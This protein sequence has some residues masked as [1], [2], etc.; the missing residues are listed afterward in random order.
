MNKTWHSP[1]ILLCLALCMTLIPSAAFGEVRKDDL[2][3]GETVEL[4]GLPASSAPAINANYAVLIDSDG[5]VYFERDADEKT[6][7]ASTT[8]MMTA[9]VALETV[10][11][12]YQIDVS[13]RAASVGE[14]SAE[15]EAGDRLTL[16]E[17]L[18]GLMVPSGNDVAVAIA[19]CV[20]SKLVD[21]AKSQDA[22]I[23]DA[24]GNAIDLYAPDASYNAFVAKMNQRA[25]ELGCSNTRF[26][27]PHGL[28][29]GEWG[30]EE[31]YSTARDIATMAS[32]A[33]E[34][35]T[36]REV[37]S[38]ARESMTVERNGSSTAINLEPTDELIGTYEDA[39]G[40][41][42]GYTE[43][44]GYCF[45]GAFEK[46][47]RYM[48]SIILD[49]PTSSQRF[50]DA[51]SLYEWELGS[52]SDYALANTDVT[53]TMELA[54]VSDSVPV[55]GYLALPAWKGRTVPVTLANPEA[56][57]RV[58]SLFGNVSQ[59]VVFE[60]VSGGVDA[61]DVVGRID[62]Y[63]NNEIIATQDLIAC[64]TVPDPNVL[65][66][67]AN[68]FGSFVDFVM[69]NDSSVESTVLNR[70]PLLLSKN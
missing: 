48:Y 47:G 12:D 21:E 50:V 67:I 63:Q 16:G 34:N 8:K 13:A 43:K 29:F 45:A 4:R 38:G 44:A 55:V 57:V 40:I 25:D 37:V 2:I 54:G 60:N 59:D 11:L 7:V 62:F 22:E 49:S 30:N 64:E 23:L 20:G 1:R 70:T 69:G 52:E 27:N 32:F 28:D 5:N 46:D 41:K 26:S 61:G 19:E 53:T 66:I 18:I 56:T 15:L 14:S 39:C 65:D 35:P 17:A 9:I 33:M 36:F 3:C 6:Q 68:G 10:P 51:K 24:D 42:T 58:S 31:L